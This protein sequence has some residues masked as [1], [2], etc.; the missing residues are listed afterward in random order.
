MARY[1]GYKTYWEMAGDAAREHRASGHWL[2][3]QPGYFNAANTVQFNV[4]WAQR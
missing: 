2:L 4:L 1:P 3:H